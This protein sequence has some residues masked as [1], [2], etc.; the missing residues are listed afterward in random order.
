M[1][2]NDGVCKSVRSNPLAQRSISADASSS[3]STSQGSNKK[4]YSV[5]H[6]DSDIKMVNTRLL[7]DEEG[8][9]VVDKGFLYG[10]PCEVMYNDRA[11]PDIVAMSVLSL[12]DKD[13]DTLQTELDMDK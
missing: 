11:H 13:Q 8:N 7:T 1:D 4:I 12:Y 10:Q 9:K 5:G 2:D 6:G 3:P